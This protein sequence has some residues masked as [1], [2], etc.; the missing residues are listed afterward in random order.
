MYN[1]RCITAQEEVLCGG[2]EGGGGGG[3]DAV[4]WLKISLLFTS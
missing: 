1:K 3:G 2:G 4:S